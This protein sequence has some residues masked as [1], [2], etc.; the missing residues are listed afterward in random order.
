L[1]DFFP[2]LDDDVFLDAMIAKSR[3]F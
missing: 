1:D 2:D 3:V